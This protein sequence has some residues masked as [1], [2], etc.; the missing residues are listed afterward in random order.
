MSSNDD[1]P[2]GGAPL[3]V[4]VLDGGVGVSS[5]SR[6]R[7]VSQDTDSLFGDPTTSYNDDNPETVA[8]VTPREPTP[9][10]RN[11]PTYGLRW[12]STD[13]ICFPK[14]EWT[15]EPTIHSIVKTLQQA[16]D[17]S[18]QYNVRHLWDG[19]Y[20]KLFSV[21][22]DQKDFVMRVSLPV[23]PKI[24]TETEITT[25][26]WIHE[27]TN[28]PVPKVECYHSSRDNP[29][30]FE[31]NLMSR[32]DGQPLSQCWNIVTQG[33]KERIVKQIAEYAATSF[34][35]QFRGIGNLYLSEPHVTDSQ[36]QVGEMVSMALF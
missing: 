15:V 9:S 7:S 6:S 10:H 14:P 32:V 8:I 36:Y 31:W 24:K 17:P 23:C 11:D 28:L 19:T 5:Q 22:Y 35:K 29:M 18:K 26:R 16:I 20:A 30:G 1:K 25:L 21:L 13:L 27:N 2:S 33:A 12:T 4:Y 3:E 34:K